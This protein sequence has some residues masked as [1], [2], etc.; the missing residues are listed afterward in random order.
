MLEILLLT[1]TIT[2]LIIASISDLKT[3]E[4]PDFI[5]YSLIII[6]LTLRLLYSLTTKDFTYLIQGL[7]GFIIFFTLSILFY[8]A[9]IWGG[10]DAKLLMGLGAVFPTYPKILLNYFTPNLNLPFLLIL[11]MNILIIGSVYGILWSIILATMNKKQFLK[12]IKPIYTKYRL[13]AHLFLILSI[14][15]LSLI[16]I[17]PETKIKLMLLI[18]SMILLIYPY[19][20]IFIKTIEKSCLIKNIDI[21]NLT[22]GD[23]LAKDVKLNNKLILSKKITEIEKKHIQLLK[24]YKIKKVL[25]KQGIPF[26]P[27]FLLSVIISLIL[28]SLI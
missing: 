25:I 28:G 1:I 16:L 14:L 20:I 15:V 3:K 17:I 7:I 21:E 10:G 13:L 27:S 2:Y 12:E 26:I 6:A 22:E 24:R 8:Y 9:K 4:V 19:L 5:S 23:W 18:L 11:I